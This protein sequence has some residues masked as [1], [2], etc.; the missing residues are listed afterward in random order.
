MIDFKEVQ[1]GRFGKC[2]MV[3]HNGLELYA[4]LDIG[5]RIIRFG[6]QKNMFGELKEFD[7]SEPTSDVYS[8]YGDLGVWHNFGGHRLWVSP[9]AMPRTYFPDNKPC[10]YEVKGDTLYLYQNNQTWTNVEASMELTFRD[11]CIEVCHKIKNTGAWEMEI[12]PW[13]LSVMDKGGTTLIPLNVPGPRYLHN[14][15]I[16]LWTYSRLTDKRLTLYD[17]YILLDQTDEEHAF[18]IGT[19]NRS[20]W[21][22]Y[23]NHGDMFV[24]YFDFDE[25]A[26]YPDGG[27][28]FE[29]YTNRRIAEVESLGGLEKLAPG[30][31]AL[32]T[33]KWRLVQGVSR[34]NSEA[35]IEKI[36]EKHIKDLTLQ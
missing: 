11:D 8:V 14:R 29:A 13:A 1:Y 3:T 31:A 26:S 12:A 34:P 20:G 6:A 30:E 33:E 17:R 32:H 28:N 22:A 21:A 18:K 16:S 35:E 25:N 36:V 9:E 7:L 10:R 23:I 19:D 4:T 5:P 24:K 2:L 15:N 27:C